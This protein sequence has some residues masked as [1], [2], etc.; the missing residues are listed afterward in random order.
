[1]KKRHLLKTMLLL[2][3]LIAGVGST[4]ATD[5][6]DVINRAATSSSLSNVATNQWADFS[7]TGTSGAS[8]TIHSMSIG[9]SGTHALQWN[10]NGYLYST[11][12]GGK[13]KSVTI[14][15]TNS[16]KVNIYASKT[17]YSEK[18]T[19][20]YLNQ[21]TISSTG[22]TYTF[23]SDYAY[24]AING[25]ESSTQITSIEIVWEEPTSDPVINAENNITI[26]ADAESGVIPYTIS[27][28]IE[29]TNLTASSTTSWI[30]NVSVGTKTVTFNVEENTGT[31]SREGT[32]TLTYGSSTTKSVT[33]TQLANF[34]VTIEEPE[35][36]TILVTTGDA[37][38]VSGNKYP[39]GTVLT[40][41]LTPDDTHKVRNWQ[42]VDAST[43][44]YTVGNTY[45]MVEHDVTLK[46]NFDEVV[47]YAVNWNVNGTVT[48]AYY[49]E[50]EDIVFP[51]QESLCGL[52]FRGWSATAI[53]GTT[54]IEP[55]FVT[56]STMGTIEQ[57]YYAVFAAVTSG[58]EI[59]IVDELTCALTGVTVVSSL[60]DATYEEWDGKTSNSDAV[61]AGMSAGYLNTIQLR[62]KNSKEGIIT[63]A[64]GGKLKK[65]VVEW[66][67]Q[68]SNARILD[69]YGSNNPYSEVS[70]LYGANTC[71][72]LLGTIAKSNQTE[73]TINGEYTYIGIR[74]DD[75]A[76]YLDKISITWETGTPDTYSNYCTTI[77]ESASATIASSGFTTY[78]SPYDLSF[79]NV[80]NLEAAYV[81]TA[82]TS[83]SATLTKVTAVPA[84]TGV[85]LKGTAG[86][87]V[88]IPVAEYT[89]SG[90]SNILVGTLEATTVTAETVYVVSGGKFMLFAGTEIPANKA[91]LPASALTGGA[92]SLSFD[93]G[94][95]TT[96]INSVERGA[97]SVEGC[98]TLDGR[99]VAQPTKGLYI[100]NGKKVVIK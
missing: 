40:V 92:P 87:E 6:T 73:L 49:E 39:A 32:I 26:A 90:I 97:L 13:L 46:A 33:I 93:F 15:G 64:S 75:G 58:D 18:A 70:A 59:T 86:E 1:M 36:G 5:V 88:S 8:Y 2:F 77:P 67:D 79:E 65:V 74:S 19:G 50:G 45:T 30:S 28:S 37:I 84:G 78:C 44:T 42:A 96:G 53:N 81:V 83:S 76:M 3:A 57:T 94:G 62:S 47:K 12:S 14:K 11:V 98:Y 95:E 82:S 25:T 52:A 56:S 63:T 23:I 38:V 10:K 17:A 48:K 35:G 27:N 16:K 100:V 69:I 9:T 34:T 4:W 54:N 29:G 71:G 99:R 21:M 85:I 80:E 7:L 61:Y 55:T 72:T 43:H 89:G 20:S 51:A 31:T 68:T 60:T 66:N 24:I 91:Y 41:T 22:A